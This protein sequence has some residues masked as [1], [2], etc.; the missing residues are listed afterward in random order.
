MVS[1]A[2]TEFSP[3]K[4]VAEENGDGFLCAC[5]HTANAPFCDG[6]HKKFD[7]DQ[8]GKEGPGVVA[9]KGALPLAEPTPEE[10]TVAFI[11]QL[12]KEGLENLGHHGPMTSMG[13]PRSELPHWDDLQIMAAQM[14]RKPLLED[15]AVDTELVVGP[16]SKK[17][18]SLKIPLFVSDM[19]FGALSEEAKISLAKGAELAGTGILLRRRGHVARGARGQLAVLL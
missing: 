15:Q 17:P 18:L 19:S 16:E 5:K 6:T 10:P 7:N 11:H 4:F 14:W 8:V 3:Q 2:G 9:K 12:A 1:H 13:V